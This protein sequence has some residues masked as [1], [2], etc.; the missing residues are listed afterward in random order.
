M[1]TVHEN[2]YSRGQIAVKW[3]G[4]IA[5][6]AAWLLCVSLALSVVGCAASNRAKY[7]VTAGRQTLVAPNGV[8]CSVPVRESPQI[9][10]EE[11]IAGRPGVRCSGA[12]GP[13]VPH[14][15]KLPPPVS[16]AF[17]EIG[18]RGVP[19]FD[20]STVA[21]LRR[22]AQYIPSK[23]LRFAYPL[24]GAQALVVYDATRGPCDAGAYQVLNLSG[25]HNAAYRP[26]EDPNHIMA[27]PAVDS[28][29]T[30]FPWMRG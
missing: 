13:R 9:S 1:S 5:S 7:G 14:P 20:A 16:Y 21:L 3:L 6:A 2:S 12:F 15:S 10:C 27:Y 25:I 29:P 8:R 18:K 26:G 22:I 23:T 28:N 30:P 11:R 17:S 24:A 19:T 4:K